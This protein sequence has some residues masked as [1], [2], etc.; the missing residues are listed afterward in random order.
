MV[1]MGL[2]IPSFLLHSVA[3]KMAVA[4]KENYRPILLMN[5]NAKILNRI[6]A[7]G[8]QEHVKMIIHH[9]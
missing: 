8:I 1:K 4:R 6:L 2:I 7:S 3:L 9:Y 5:L